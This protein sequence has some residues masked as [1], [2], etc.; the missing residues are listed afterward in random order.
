M[1]D[2]FSDA[3]KKTLA[4]RVGYVCSNPTCR[5]ST[6]GPQEDPTKAINLGVAAHITAAS[7]GGPRYD[8]NLSPEQRS[9]A[10]N[11]IWLCQT[12]AKLIDSDVIRFS[13]EILHKWKAGAE[14]EAKSRLGKTTATSISDLFMDVS[15]IN[16][17][18]SSWK[19]GEETILQYDL[20]REGDR[21][22]VHS[23]LGYATLFTHGGPISPLEYTM[24]PTYCPFR[25]D[26]PILDFKVL[27]NRET[28]LFLTEIVFDIEESRTDHNPLLTIKR[29]TQQRYAGELLLINEGCCALADLKISFHLLPGTITN[30]SDILSPYPHSISVPL[31]EDH[32]ELDVTGAFQKEGVD[33]KGL[34]LL[35]N[36]T[37]DQNVFIAPKPD[38]SEERMTEAEMQARWEECLGPFRAEVGT[39]VGEISFKIKN[40]A[41][42][43]NPV[44]FSAPV[45]LTNKNRYGLLKPPSYK[46]DSAFD[47]Q[48]I[49]Y[50][51]RVQI[52]HSL[53]PGEADRFTVKLAVAKS[54]F[55]RFRATLRDVTGLIWESLPIEMNC[56]VPRSRWKV[57]AN[58]I[59]PK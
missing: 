7:P 14:A 52:S 40:D 22:K 29:D 12:C 16:E 48:G 19:R 45:Y 47:I 49:N 39:L 34:I 4:A 56:F 32:V 42:L 13:V 20:D 6:S 35:S 58:A 31:L 28:P 50:Q 25:W 9:A 18:A 3:V 2:D 24:S 57:V 27:N 51:R 26:F 46:Y 55:H 59:S 38:G 15:V 43:N 41:G 8:S 10:L 23:K 1:S 21:I 54:S 30:F 53:Q 33:I 44:R 36:G 17:D 5:A 37:W 11:G